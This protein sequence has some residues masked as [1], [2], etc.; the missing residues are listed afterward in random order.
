MQETQAVVVT[1]ARTGIGAAI[2][3]ELAQRGFV[4]AC[5]SRR[6]ARP[7]AP[8][9]LEG[10]LRPYACDVTNDQAFSQV[11]ADA[12]A[13][14]DR[15]VGLVNNA[16]TIQE[17]ASATLT[18]D[19]LREV[20]EVNFVS[21]FACARASYPFLKGGGGLIVNIGSFYDRLGVRRHLAYSA[22]KAA[23]S[24]MGKTLA[25]EWAPDGVRVVTV[26]PGYVETALNE[27]VLSD[28]AARDAV[29]RR[30]PVRRL[31]RTSEIGQLVATLFSEPVD[32]LTGTT[33]YVD[34][35]QSIRL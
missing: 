19:E 1:G 27:E 28:S 7:A 9:A 32:F 25:V 34:G 29:T 17:E 20:L 3:V 23:L 31:G 13:H 22:S 4:V 33:V 15:I 11:L 2:A 10:R 18:R 24:N 30:I 12:A 8:A 5:L 21:A 14:C 35:A 26:A 6:G 16:G